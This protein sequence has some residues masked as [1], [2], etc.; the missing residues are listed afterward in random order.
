VPLD[1]AYPQDV[2]SLSHIALPFPADDGLNGIAPDPADD[3]G[4]SLGTAAPRGERGA[5]V[6]EIDMLLRLPSNPFFPYL[7]ARTE[8]LMMA[9]PAR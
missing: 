8:E 9:S 2:F 7:L 4:V 5:L 6:V 3:F 1:L